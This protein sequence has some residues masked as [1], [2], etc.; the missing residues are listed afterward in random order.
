MFAAFAVAALV[1]RSWASPAVPASAA[2]AE[3]PVPRQPRSAM[4]LI[5]MVFL[6][7]V[8]G[9]RYKVG[10]DWHN[11]ELAYGNIQRL[12]LSEALG[13]LRQEPAYTIVNWIGAQVG[14]GLWFGN[15]MCAIPF[16]WGLMRI[17]RQQPNPWLAV[18][19]ATPFLII[20]VGMGFTRQGAALG[21][22]MAG[23]AD[24]IETRSLVRFVV[25]TLLG[26]LFHR[27]VLVFIPVILLA[28]GR[29]KIVSLALAVLAA[30]IA[31]ATIFT[32]AAE[33]Y[34]VGYLNGRFDAAGAKVRVLMN[35]LPALLLLVT[36]DRM[37]RSR[38]EK[39]VWKTFAILSVAAG[40]GLLLVTSSVIV[41]RLAM[42]LIPIQLFVLARISFLSADP[43]S[44]TAWRALVIAYSAAVL[45]VWLNFGYYSAGWL[46]YRNYLTSPTDAPA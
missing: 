41:D 6:I 18:L 23:L 28:A 2:A 25:Y 27:T 31:Y 16:C 35:V 45:F 36:K 22:L 19:V 7:V 15:L 3:W 40:I 10:G 30:G 11:Y 20:V 32:G 17:C 26:S 24:Y 12:S 33:Y 29:N 38:E 34:Q 21:F 46:P 13:R 39:V 14:A 37:Y 4:P 42:Y 8:I 44:D 1:S 9:L 5:V 43:R